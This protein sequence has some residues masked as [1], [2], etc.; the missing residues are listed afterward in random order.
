MYEELEGPFIF[1]INSI[2][3]KVVFSEVSVKKPLL[4]NRNIKKKVFRAKNMRSSMSPIG[5]KLFSD[6]VRIEIHA[7]RRQYL[8]RRIGESLKF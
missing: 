1:S 2:C 6:E 8:K 7:K 3:V 5:K 4:S